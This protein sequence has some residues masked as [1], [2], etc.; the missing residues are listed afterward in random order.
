MLPLS[1]KVILRLLVIIQ[2]LAN[3]L[4]EDR[5]NTAVVVDTVLPELP[6][7]TGRFRYRQQTKIFAVPASSREIDVALSTGPV[8]ADALD[9]DSPIKSVFL[10]SRRSN[11]RLK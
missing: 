11:K 3:L 8:S 4:V 9:V 5:L 10:S 2:Y 1:S 6:G 7:V